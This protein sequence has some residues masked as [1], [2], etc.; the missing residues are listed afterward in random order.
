MDGDLAGG[1][2][3]QSGLEHITQND[4]VD[5]LGRQLKALQGFFHCYH[6]QFHRRNTAQR[7]AETADRRP[8]RTDDDRLLHFCLRNR[9][10]KN[11]GLSLN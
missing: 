9:D 3:S 7:P 11:T 1:V 2:L 5:L 4:F 6:P 10:L 8:H